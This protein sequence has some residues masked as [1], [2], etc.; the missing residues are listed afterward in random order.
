MARRT[1]TA[2]KYSVETPG[3]L[4]RAAVEVFAEL[5]YE[6][7]ST[8]EI[9]RRAGANQ[10]QIGYHFGSKEALWKAA[11][12]SVNAD[13]QAA[14]A[15]TFNTAG[16]GEADPMRRV[17]RAY[18]TF[19]WRNPEWPI[20]IVQAGMG[21][22]ERVDW[23]FDTIVRPMMAWVMDGLVPSHALDAGSPA[24]MRALSLFSMLGGTALVFIAKEQNRRM[25]D[26][27]TQT[28]AYFEAHLEVVYTGL[29]SVIEAGLLD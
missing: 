8:R 7:A 16:E 28:D 25:F 5:G 9:S 26:I 4:L 20:L 15:D 3:K 21:T 27:D 19:A 6:G 18:L 11:M 1:S 12:E 10:S 23:L 17:V 22:S 13:F 2:E 29:T 14:I 24:R